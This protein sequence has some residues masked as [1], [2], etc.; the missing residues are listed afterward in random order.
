MNWGKRADS[1]GAQIV[2]FSNNQSTESIGYYNFLT[3]AP[4]N[5]QNQA[6]NNGFGSVNTSN[7]IN[8]AL[9]QSAPIYQPQKEYTV[10]YFYR[11]ESITGIYP[12]DLSDLDKSRTGYLEGIKAKVISKKS[13]A[14]GEIL[15]DDII[16]KINDI[17]VRDVSHFV[18]ISNY[19]KKETVKF[20]ILRKGQ[21][22]TKEIS[23]T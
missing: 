23:I 12:I 15:E 19:L 21:K 14:F 9:T 5:S 11:F 10:S 22:M 13:A 18:D 6:E 8:G 3:P 2:L 20:E 7:N 17:V 4:H 16:L 1:L